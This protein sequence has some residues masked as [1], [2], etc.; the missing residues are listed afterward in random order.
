ML[1]GSSRF[2][3]VHGEWLCNGTDY[4]FHLDEESKGTHRSVQDYP[5]VYVTDLWRIDGIHIKLTAE[6]KKYLDEPYTPQKIVSGSDQGG[7][8]L[9]NHYQSGFK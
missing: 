6:E 3:L 1:N 8:P 4:R 7:H 2:G 9:T 5:Q